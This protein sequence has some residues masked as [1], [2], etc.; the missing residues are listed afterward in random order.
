MECASNW[1]IDMTSPDGKDL[2]TVSLKKIE[3]ETILYSKNGISIRLKL[4]DK[5]KE[6][7]RA[8]EGK[9]IIDMKRIPNPE[10]KKNLLIEDIEEFKNMEIK[11]IIEDGFSFQ[12][13][14]INL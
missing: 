14:F 8:L 3:C 13:N 11:D 5:K 7:I 4:D 12:I 6:F 1:E 10:C 2:L 9:Y